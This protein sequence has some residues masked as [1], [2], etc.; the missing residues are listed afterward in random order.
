MDLY[1]LVLKIIS[2][3]IEDAINENFGSVKPRKDFSEDTKWMILSMQRHLCNHC[4]RILDVVNFDHIDGD[5]SNNHI[6]NCQA[7]CPNCHARKTR[8]KKF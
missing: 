3:A 1:T 7:L 8:S 4:D 6:S 5:R 2:S